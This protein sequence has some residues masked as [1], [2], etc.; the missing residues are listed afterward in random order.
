MILAENP[1]LSYQAI[2]V[3]RQRSVEQLHAERYHSEMVERY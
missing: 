1:L 2:F 3:E